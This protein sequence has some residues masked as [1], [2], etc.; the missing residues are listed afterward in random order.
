[1]G[2]SLESILFFEV[3]SNEMKFLLTTLT[4]FIVISS[5][6]NAQQGPPGPRGPP[7]PPGVTPCT[8]HCADK[9]CE[10]LCLVGCCGF[11]GHYGRGYMDGNGNILKKM[12]EEY[13]GSYEK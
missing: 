6:T 12:D 2:N 1:M 3:L 8:G 7:G 10:P 4:F 11:H 9:N 13:D 5:Y